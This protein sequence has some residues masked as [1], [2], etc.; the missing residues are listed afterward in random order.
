MTQAAR[1]IL[2]KRVGPDGKEIHCEDNQSKWVDIKETKKAKYERGK[3]QAYQKTV[4]EY[5]KNSERREYEEPNKITFKNPENESQKIEYLRDKG[6]NHGVTK[7]RYSEAGRGEHY[8]KTKIHY[9][10]T[11][12]NDARL[13]R[14]QEVTNPDTGDKIK[15]ERLERWSNDWARGFA[16]QK[17]KVT[18][19]STEQNIKDMEGDCKEVP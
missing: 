9:C 4:Y 14:I 15:I 8:Q 6:P 3:G 1:Q 19:C 16:Y 12:D 13:K 2:K 7:N 18:P 10:N 5:C 17:K 11:A